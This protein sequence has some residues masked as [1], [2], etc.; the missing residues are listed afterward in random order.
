MEV[1]EIDLGNGAKGVDWKPFA[2]SLKSDPELAPHLDK[3]PEKDVTSLIKSHVHLNRRMGSALNLP[4][5]DAKDEDKKAF[6]D[7]VYGT[8]LIA[9]APESP[10]KYEITIPQADKL[11]PGLKFDEATA[12]EFR[13]V[14]HKLGLT[15]DQV[16]GLL[17]F[18]TGRMGKIAGQQ[19]ADSETTMTALKK[20]W[21]ADFNSRAELA[22]RATAY[23]FQK[24]PAA[25]DFLNGTGMGNHPQFIK[26]MEFVGRN[27][28]H[29]DGFMRAQNNAIAMTEARKEIDAIRA[30]PKHP[31]HEKWVKGDAAT[32]AHMDELYKQEDA[33]LKKQNA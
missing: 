19:M 13:G 21:G 10:D 24:D 7:K 15:Q 12:N 18:D 5:K 9:R 27:L 26:I 4:G 33:E 14:A 23:L 16:K 22:G 17:E 11:P 30:D 8:G 25:Q 6:L 28:E 1:A 31:M 3:I 20:D 2:E 29:D 32:R